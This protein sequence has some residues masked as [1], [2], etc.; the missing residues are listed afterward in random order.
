MKT[1]IENRENLAEW[2]R[3]YPNWL[4]KVLWVVLLP[5]FIVAPMFGK[6]SLFEVLKEWWVVMRT[7]YKDSNE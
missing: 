3:R 6:G 5:I 4:L 2:C 7:T 1:R